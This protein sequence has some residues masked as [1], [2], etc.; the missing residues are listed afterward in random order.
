[1]ETREVLGIKARVAKSFFE[2]TRGLIGTKHLP[3]GE[4]MLIERCN[5]IHT[6]FMSFPIDVTFLD[7]KGGIVK[8]VRGVKPWRAIVWGGWRAKMALETSAENI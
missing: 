1:M 2:R 5:A 4:G 8:Q 3:Q 7:G 6:F